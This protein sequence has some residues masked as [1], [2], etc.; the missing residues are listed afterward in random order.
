MKLTLIYWIPRKREFCQFLQYPVRANH[1]K[2][3]LKPTWSLL[4]AFETVIMTNYS[5]AC[6]DKVSLMTS[7]GIYW[8]TYEQIRNIKVVMIKTYNVHCIPSAKVLQ[9]FFYFP[10]CYFMQDIDEWHRNHKG[11]IDQPEACQC[12]PH[13][14]LWLRVGVD[15]TVY[16]IICGQ[17]RLLVTQGQG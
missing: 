11:L 6:D 7:L 4:I 10:A 9:F 13:N 2:N 16:Y 3:S 12:Y 15:H 1:W 17:P 8:M 14:T 5:A